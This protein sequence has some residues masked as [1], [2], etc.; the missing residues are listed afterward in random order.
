MKIRHVFALHSLDQA[1][2]AVRIAFKHD[3]E[4]E[5]ISLVAKGETQLEQIPDSLKD[6]SSTDFI[7]AALRGTAGG[8]GVGLLAGL[9]AAAIPTAGVTLAGAGLFALGGAAIGGWSA[10]LVGASVPNEVQ[11]QFE[12]R[13]ERGEVLLVLDVEEDQTQ[14]LEAELQAIGAQRVEYEAI[15]SMV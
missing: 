12:E 5:S 7:P 15:S 11:R 3:L 2:E 10:A 1:T 8:G 6:A 13:V 14:P 9:V 4:S